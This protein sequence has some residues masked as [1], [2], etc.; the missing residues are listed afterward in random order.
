MI[1][2]WS[3][4]CTKAGVTLRG[5]PGLEQEL[6]QVTLRAPREG[7]AVMPSPLEQALHPLQSA[8]PP[9]QYSPAPWDCLEHFPALPEEIH[10]P[11][12]GGRQKM[13]LWTSVWTLLPPETSSLAMDTWIC[14]WRKKKDLFSLPQRLQFSACFCHTALVLQVGQ[15]QNFLWNHQNLDIYG[16][17]DGVVKCDG[18]SILCSVL[19]YLCALLTMPMVE[20]GWDCCELWFQ[21]DWWCHTLV[22]EDCQWWA[23]PGQV[24]VSFRNLWKL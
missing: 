5:D 17:S 1:V 11:G 3:S 14:V 9:L 6:L 2:Q 8:L 10:S 19:W 22:L 7:T 20:S 18:K 13:L 23:T 15:L 21:E 4:F 24:E 12:A 16:Y